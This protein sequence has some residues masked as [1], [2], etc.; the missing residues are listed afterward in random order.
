M[1]CNQTFC[2]INSG[3]LEEVNLDFNLRYETTLSGSC[4]VT[5]KDEHF[6]FGGDLEV[7]K[8]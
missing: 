6:M 8:G 3:S 7:Y 4:G 1:Q 5:F 2:N